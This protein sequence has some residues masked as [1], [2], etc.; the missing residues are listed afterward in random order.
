MVSSFTQGASHEAENPI[1]LSLRQA[2]ESIEPKLRPPFSLTIPN[3][4]E[5]L[6]LNRAI[7]YVVPKACC[8]SE[9][10]VDLGY[11]GNGSCV[12]SWF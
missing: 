2:F 6:E 5:Y 4:D 11:Q 8:V 3:P 10:S 7:L 9:K 1:E 12:G